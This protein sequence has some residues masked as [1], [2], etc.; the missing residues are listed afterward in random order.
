MSGLVLAVVVFGC[1]APDPLQQ[2]AADY[3]A[4]IRGL[5]AENSDLEQNFVDLSRE[6]HQNALSQEDIAE[7]L[8]SELIPGA[9]ALEDKATAAAPTAPELAVLHSQLEK[10][11]GDRT[12]SWKAI[13]SA[14]EAADVDGIQVAMTER[15]E[16]RLAEERY[17]LDAAAILRPY[18]ESIPRTP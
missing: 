5:M 14:F 18:G 15:A 17:L 1:D 9:S 16:S 8:K 10:A 3:A 7:A 2:P 11:W 4:D 6:L 12:R 13:H